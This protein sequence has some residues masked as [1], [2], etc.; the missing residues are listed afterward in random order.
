[1]KKTILTCG[2]LALFSWST[3]QN[4]DETRAKNA[5]F[6]VGASYGAALAVGDFADSDL[7]NPDAGF[8]KNGR[9]MEVFG[10]HFL[11]RNDRVTITGIFRYQQFNT[12]LDDLIA[13]LTEDN[14]GVAYTGTSE[15][16]ETYSLLFG[17]AYKI[18]VTKRFEVFPRAA[19]GPMAVTT[20]GI[21]VNSPD[22]PM[23]QN[24]SRTSETGVG[25]GYEFGVGLK[26]DIGRRLSLVPSFTFSG[27]FVNIKDVI[28]TSDN[29]TTI[30]NF[31]PKLFSFN[32]GISVAYRFY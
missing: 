26:K 11:N 23:A 1:M 9:K 29:E 30:D 21:T 17:I 24:F 19:M 25:I 32:L 10:G 8:A 15:E 14:P 5:S 13:S 18:G 31:Q 7:T 20:P 6:Y 2:L 22:S 3:A 12:E 28:V 27:G 4:T 16:W